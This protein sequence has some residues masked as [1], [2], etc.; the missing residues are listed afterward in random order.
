MI[1][2]AASVVAGGVRR[3][4]VLVDGFR[5]EVEVESERIAALRERASRGR[6]AS[7]HAGPLQVKAIIPGKVVAVSVDGGRRGDGRPA[8]AGRRGHED[9][10][11]APGA[12]GRHHRT[13][14]RRGGRQHRDRRP[15]RGDQLA[16]DRV[17]QEARASHGAGDGDG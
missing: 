15:A 2:E 16:E 13:R 6:A 5:F 4:E 11:R 8:A 10:E 17:N 7:A 12:A 14:R 1:L 9:A 3:R